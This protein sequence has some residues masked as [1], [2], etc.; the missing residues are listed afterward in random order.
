MGNNIERRGSWHLVEIK[1]ARNIL[2]NPQTIWEQYLSLG[3]ELEKLGR[4]ILRS[5]VS[6]YYRKLFGNNPSQTEFATNMLCVT[7]LI[8]NFKG[9]IESLEDLIRLAEEIAAEEPYE[10]TSLQTENQDDS[11]VHS[12]KIA[13]T[14]KKLETNVS[15]QIIA[16]RSKH[17]TIRKAT[18]PRNNDE[19]D[20]QGPEKKMASNE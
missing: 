18:S 8:N 6:I 11:G 4:P 14:I 15:Q 19:D 5:E 17:P 1:T 12:A 13:E 10:H 3:K 7:F 2:E 16:S 9:T 20:D